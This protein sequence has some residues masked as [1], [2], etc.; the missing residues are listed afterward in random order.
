MGINPKMKGFP[1]KKDQSEKKQREASPSNL[2]YSPS[3]MR[4]GEEYDARSEALA[5]YVRKNKAK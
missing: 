2:K 5:A 1:F 3:E 4:E